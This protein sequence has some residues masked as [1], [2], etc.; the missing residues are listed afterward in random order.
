MYDNLINNISILVNT[1]SNSELF[2]YGR[3]L[4]YKERLMFDYYVKCLNNNETF[5]EISAF[6][7]HESEFINKLIDNNELSY[8]L[9]NIDKIIRN[10]SSFDN[11]LF[12]YLKEN[13][14]KIHSDIIDKIYMLIAQSISQFYP[15]VKKENIDKLKQLVKNVVEEENASIF[16]I[17]K[18]DYGGYSKIYKINDKIIKVG[19][20][21]ECEKIINNNRLLIPEFKGL[22]GADYVEITDYLSDKDNIGD[23]DVYNVYKDLRNQGLIWLDPTVKNLAR[24]SKKALLN[25]YINKK[26]I[27]NLD[28]IENPNYIE[29]NLSIGDLV[30]ID[31]DHIIFDFDIEKKKKIESSLNEFVVG[32]IKKYEAR[33]EKENKVLQKII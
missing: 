22:I 30:I 18:V 24:L 16:D 29:P 11:N 25:Q 1:L 27:D 21:R 13:Q 8:I 6:Y 32:K 12:D 19:Y 23:E 4:E 7:M 17:R 5:S 33:Y 20:K 15:N 3:K 10:D 9:D 2:D 26:N 28:I 14:N 31:L